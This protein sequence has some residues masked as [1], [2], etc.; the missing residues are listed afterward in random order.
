MRKWFMTGF[1]AT[2]VFFAF[3]PSISAQTYKYVDKDG[4]TH[5]TNIPNSP[6]Y[7]PASGYVNQSPKKKS[8]KP[9]KK[10]KIKKDPSSI[11]K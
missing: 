1:M 10:M 2:L 8:P 7:K 4:V 9:I 5:F 6:K 3:A 11:S